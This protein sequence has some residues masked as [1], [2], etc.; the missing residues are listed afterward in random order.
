MLIEDVDIQQVQKLI[1]P[2]CLLGLI[3]FSF[4][5]AGAICYGSDD[6]FQ[7]RP[8]AGIPWEANK[9]WRLTY[10]E[11]LRFNDGGGTYIPGNP[12]LGC[13]TNPLRNG[14]ISVLITLLSMGT[15]AL[16]KTDYL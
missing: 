13:C 14:L 6:N 10:R 15:S 8:S 3:L 7:L 4:P 1:K 16:A 5:P 12:I 9:D 11:L 2:I